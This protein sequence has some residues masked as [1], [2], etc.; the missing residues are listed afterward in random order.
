VARLG[1]LRRANQRRR[2]QVPPVRPRDPGT[3]YLDGQQ[4]GDARQR[5]RVQ[6]SEPAPVKQSQGDQEGMHLG[7]PREAST[8]R[9]Y[10]APGLRPCIPI[11]CLLH[12]YTVTAMEVYA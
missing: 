5:G 12:G 10:C 8:T 9:H 11:H 2:H 6:L 4:Q 1:S 3:G 7:G